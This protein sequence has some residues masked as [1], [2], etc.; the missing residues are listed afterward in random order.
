MKDERNKVDAVNYRPAVIKGKS[1]RTCTI[2]QT[3]PWM[4]CDVIM[5]QADMGRVCDKWTQSA[6]LKQGVANGP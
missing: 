1:C 6:G 2:K 4:W 5:R 3:V